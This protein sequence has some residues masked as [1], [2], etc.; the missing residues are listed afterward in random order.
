VA[1]QVPLPSALALMFDSSFSS[2]RHPV[3]PALTIFNCLATIGEFAIATHP[4]I[5]KTTTTTTL[6]R[7]TIV[8]LGLHRQRF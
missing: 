2:G 5:P 4:V 1:F 7:N 6:A 3:C 8:L